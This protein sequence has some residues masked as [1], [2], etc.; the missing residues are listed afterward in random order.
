[1]LLL[2]DGCVLPYEVGPLE[3]AV[4]QSGVPVSPCHNNTILRRG[5]CISCV[6]FVVH[7][8]AAGQ[9]FDVKKISAV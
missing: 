7:L 1:M 9:R 2:L 3:A 6:L 4:R 8:H 5:F